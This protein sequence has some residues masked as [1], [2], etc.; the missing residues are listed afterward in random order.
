MEK[1]KK[2]PEEELYLASQPTEP[3][4]TPDPVAEDKTATRRKTPV[5]EEVVRVAEMRELRG[6]NFKV[7]EMSDGSEQAVFYPSTVHVW[8]DDRTCYEDIDTALIAEKDGRHFCNKKGSFTA[9]FSREENNDE[10]FSIE[11]GAHRVTVFSKKNFKHLNRDVHP[12]IRKSRLRVSEHTDILAFEEVAPHIDMEYSVTAAGV[13]GNIVIKEKTNVYQFPF[14]LRCAHVTYRFNEEEKQVV[15]LSEET[16]KEVFFIP[17]PF[18]K[19]ANDAV[20]TAVSY[21]VK[22]AANGNVHFTVIADSEWINAPGRAFPVT[23]APQILMLGTSSFTTYSCDNGYLY[24]P[25]LHKVGTVTT[26]VST[27]LPITSCGTGESMQDAIPLS[28]DGW[29][30]GTIATP[31][32]EVWYQFT[33]NASN[34]HTNGAPGPYTIQTDGPLDTVCCLYNECGTLLASTDECKRLNLCITEQLT[35]GATYY[36]RIKGFSN[37]TGSYSISVGYT[38]C[39]T[40]AINGSVHRLYMSFNMPDLPRNPRISKAELTFYQYEGS[41]SDGVLPLLGLYQVTSNLITGCC[42]PSHDDSLIDYAKMKV[43]HLEEGQVISYTFD[44]TKLIDEINKGESCSS[45]LMIKM[46]EENQNTNRHITLYGS[47][48]G[49]YSPKLYITYQ[50]NYGVNTAYRTHTHEIGCFGQGSIDLACGNLIFESEDFVWA[51][52]HQPVT[53][54]HLFNSALAGYQYTRNPEIGL[55]CAN[56]SSMNL[57]YGFWLNLMQSMTELTFREEEQLYDGFVYIDEN[58]NETYFKRGSKQHCSDSNS[59]RYNLYEDADGAGMLYDPYERTLIKGDNRYLFDTSGRLIRITDQSGNQ[60]QIT[61]TANRISSLTDGAGRNFAFAYN[62][63]GFLTSIAAPDNTRIVYSYAGNQLSSV[64]YPGGKKATFI[65][66]NGK[67]FTVTLEDNCGR[68]LCKVAYSFR[69]DRAYRVTEYG[70]KNGT[71]VTGASTTYSYSAASRRTL[72]Q[73]TEQADPDA[74]ELR[75]NVM[76]TVYTFDHTGNIVSKYLYTQDTCNSGTD[77]KESGIHPYA[78]EGATCIDAAQSES[79]PYSNAYNMLANGNFERGMEQ[80]ICSAGASYSTTTRFNMSKSAYIVGNID[81]QRQ[82]SQIVTVKDECSTRETFTL[83]GWAKGHG[84]PDHDRDGV[85]TPLF[86]LRAHMI[87]ADNNE[88]EDFIADFSPCTED[89]QF[90]SVQFAKSKYRPVKELRVYCDYGYNVDRAYFADIH[91]I[92]NHVETGLSESDFVLESSVGDDT[93]P[94]TTKAEKV[95]ETT[96]GFIEVIDEYGNLITETTYTDGESG[97]IY[98]AFEYVPNCFGTEMSTMT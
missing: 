60:L 57:G 43:G 69:G 39:S 2:I 79:N 29:H 36:V 14:I 56:F 24:T 92:R 9:R 59:S 26:A 42:T 47:T 51:G 86:R 37:K 19:D 67:P 75:N 45:R 10:L 30:R 18:M 20:S 53:I 98:R 6:E 72:I 55:R 74:Y 54:R 44:V 35:Y 34:A 90:A 63:S 94:V 78:G 65:W 97:T 31:G 4:H 8:N 22:P 46:M 32:A 49:T 73:T 84:L 3:E 17:V 66:S 76:K 7:F 68:P 27:A 87:Y 15:F 58:G 13:K 71:L 89:W 81:E 11:Q 38:N 5:L 25:S 50:A 96:P 16:G 93:L 23:I 41:S 64:T 85:H 48:S 40:C 12:E 80:W 82:F 91:L 28:F 95:Q 21:E 88:S 70:V 77:S 1:E 62:A 33:A 83:S 52:E 61:Y